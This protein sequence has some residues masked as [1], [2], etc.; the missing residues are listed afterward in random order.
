MRVAAR[1]LGLSFEI[2]SPPAAHP[3]RTDIGG[4]IGTIAR[5]P[6]TA[7]P[8]AMPAV[9][10]RWLRDLGFAAIG[11]APADALEVDLESGAAFVRSLLAQAG[12]ER[13]LLEAALSFSGLDS[14]T[15]GSRAAQLDALVA[16]CRSLSPLPAVLL[17]EL[18]ERGFAPRRLILGDELAAWLRLQRLANV[19]FAVESFEAFEH[20]F[21]WEQRPVLNRPIEPGDPLVATA[22]GAAVRAFFS[23]G[24]RRCWIVRTGDPAPV[25]ASARE[26]F[27]ACF[28]EARPISDADGPAGPDTDGRCVQ[29]T[30]V[31]RL[32]RSGLLADA[33]VDPL[34]VDSQPAQ[35]Q[36][37][38]HAYGLSELSF[39]CLPDLIDACAQDVPAVLA[40]VP[41][42]AAPEGF[43]DCV[44]PLSP[45]TPPAGRRLPAP[46]LNSL[47]LQV[48]RALVMRGLD[49]LGNSGRAYHRRDVQLLASLPLTGD[50]RD[51]PSGGD[52]VEW[53][54]GTGWLD[55]GAEDGLLNDRLQLAYPWLITRASSVCPGGVEAPEGRLA[56]VFAR[57]ALQRGS[58]RS[59]AG[60]AVNGYIAT[61]P[62]LDWTRAM[63]RQ[64]LTPLGP[65]ALAERVCLIGPS[66]R[67]AQLRSDATCAAQAELRQGAVRRLLNVVMQAAR[68]AGEE[69]A[70]EANGEALWASV[71]ERLNDLGRVLLAAG[72]LS[73]D[74]IPFAAR[75]GRETM[76]QA[77]LDA[78]R[79]IAEI[80]LLA[81][82]PIQRIVV[83][84]ALRDALPRAELRAA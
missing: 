26:R 46:R 22:L 62:V 54:A 44:Q 79:L 11:G 55:R 50:G 25:F 83:V 60:Q 57:G 64:A 9:L 72:A 69:F 51:L 42:T 10:A 81:A 56:G 58:F 66:P 76:T 75:C 49:L 70:F 59:L 84:L 3:N 5:R 19:P 41:E 53:M 43:H 17:D 6:S 52:W 21:A 16:A 80:E 45:V 47:S 37:L 39:A 65:L 40:P 20:L 73:T 28:P 74:G 67:G 77:D 36:G 15:A 18:I 33:R 71:R 63:Q 1:P 14:A 32:I 68:T 24:G 78:G 48:W 31:A 13:P 7:S 2:A 38:E 8:R 34:P 29:L 82:Q 4:F 23:E 27:A 61:E 12:A 35:W 30:G